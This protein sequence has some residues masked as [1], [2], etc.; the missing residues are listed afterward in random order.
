MKKL[1]FFTFVV[2]VVLSV[3]KSF[4]Y[5]VPEDDSNVE[6]LYVTGPNGDPLGGAE[7]HTQVLHIDIP[8][9]EQGAVSIGIFDPDTGG[10]IDLKPN[11]SSSW[12]TKTVITIFGSDGKIAKKKFDDD[13]KYNNEF[14]YFKSFPKTDG[15][16]IGNFYRFTLEITAVSGE[17]AN[18][19]KVAVS[20][21][22]AGVSSPNITFR[23]KEAE[24]S[25]MYF[26]PLI[27]EGIDQIIVSNYDLDHDGGISS[28]HDPDGGKDYDI[29]DSLSGQWHDTVVDLSSTHERF[30]D[31]RII[32]GTQ[33]ESHAGIKITD[34]DGNPIPIYF[35]KRSLGGCDEF[36]FDAT[37]SFDPDNQALVYHWD[38]GDGNVSEEAVVT[39][40]FEQGGDYNVILSVQD[41]SGLE[42]DTSVASQVVTVN[43]PPVAALTGPG[44]ACTSQ[45]VTFDASGTT[46]STPGQ[47][48]YNWDFGD[49]TSAEGVQVTKSFDKGGTY[50]VQ[51]DVNDN[52][53][54]TC[55]TDSTGKLIT[56]NTNPVANA[57]QDIRVTIADLSSDNIGSHDLDLTGTARNAVTGADKATV[58]NTVTAGEDLTVAGHIGTTTVDVLVN[59]TARD[60][61]ALVNGVRNDTGVEATAITKAKLDT[62]SGVGTYT[63]NI[64]GKNTSS[65][66]NISFN[67]T[68]TADLTNLA[69]AFNSKAGTTG[70]TAEL[71]ADKAAVTLTQ[72]EGYDIVIEDVLETGGSAATINMTG[73]DQDNAN[74]GAAVS[75]GAAVGTDTGRSAGSV[76]FSSAKD[77]T[78]KSAAAGGLFALTTSNGSSLTDVASLNI[79]TQVS[80]NGAITVLD[81]ALT[82]LQDERANLGAIQNRLETTVSNLENISSNISASRSAV[83][84]ADFAKESSLLAR[85]K[86]LQQA[87]TAM[88]AQ[89]NQSMQGVMKCMK[90]GQQQFTNCFGP[91]FAQRQQFIHERTQFHKQLSIAGQ[92]S[93]V[94]VCHV[95][96]LC[97]P[98]M[99]QRRRRVIGCG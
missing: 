44:K 12:D 42:C 4:A 32:K 2:V 92:K 27:P 25:K 84:D 31:Y 29:E 93:R 60:V 30:L 89:A 85:D 3:T 80:A 33:F 63:M 11:S 64:Y 6:F 45:V 53:G 49:G 37:S 61:A 34:K 96:G 76:S 75:L 57:G 97:I 66:V 94:G 17:D 70:I 55:S 56:I 67:I 77:Y 90:A 99:L 14:Y 81:G 52:A 88:L 58:V 22:S 8:E 10:D 74:A 78:V 50:N 46:D 43:T 40:R 24:G 48:T 16:K 54:T 65:P 79:T 35:R 72:A 38:F 21:G 62:V 26:F 36:T 51:L 19:F 41:S 86:I 13:G 47:I 73:L 82:L 5:T 71:S 9:D 68:K 20:P 95:R 91:P 18:L 1:L 59:N 98:H 83:E 87:G 28:F 69:E 15:E 23:L 7:D 39:H